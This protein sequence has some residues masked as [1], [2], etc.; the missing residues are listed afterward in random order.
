MLNFMEAFNEAMLILF[1][2]YLPALTNYQ[3]EPSFE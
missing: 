1:V 2:T 3:P